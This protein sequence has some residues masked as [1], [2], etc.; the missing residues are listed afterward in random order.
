MQHKELS[1]IKTWFG[2]IPQNK[3][4]FSFLFSIH[5]WFGRRSRRNAAQD[6]FNPQSCIIPTNEKEVKKKISLS[7]DLR[8][9]RQ[10]ERE[11]RRGGE[12]RDRERVKGYDK[13]RDR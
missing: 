12:D 10:K 6:I 1:C 7:T 9:T 13:E 5:F 11:R 4:D 8:Q 3:D 2:N